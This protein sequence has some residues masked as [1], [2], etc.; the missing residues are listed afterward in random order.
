MRTGV[1]AAGAGKYRNLLIEAIVALS[2]GDPPNAFPPGGIWCGVSAVDVRSAA[3]P[4]RWHVS[5]E[6]AAI[7][8][9][10]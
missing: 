6:I 8:G 2:G 3:S 7:A 9:W 4:Y 5:T 1:D 10:W